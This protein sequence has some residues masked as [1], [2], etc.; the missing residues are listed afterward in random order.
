VELSPQLI[1]DHDCLIILTDH[2][3]YDFRS[4]VEAAKLVIDTR[5]AT[6]GFDAFK[7]RIIKLGAGNKTAGAGHHEDELEI[8]SAAQF[9]H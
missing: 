9:R 3:A 1:A 7:D 6:K 4:V 8:G 2:S 5:N